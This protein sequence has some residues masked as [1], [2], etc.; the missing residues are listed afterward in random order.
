MN[1]MCNIC[2][3]SIKCTLVS[4]WKKEKPHRKTVQPLQV[5][6]LEDLCGDD[7]A[8]FGN[9]GG[10]DDDDLVDFLDTVQFSDV[11]P[12]RGG[13]G[14]IGCLNCCGNSPPPQ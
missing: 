6:L 3:M 10:A 5:D 1:T 13:I 4:C 9:D 7:F 2:K 12:V 8:V 14:F 11:T